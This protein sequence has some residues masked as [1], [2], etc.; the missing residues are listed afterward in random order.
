ML[1]QRARGF[2]NTCSSASLSFN[3]VSLPGTRIHSGPSR[4]PVQLHVLVPV[5]VPGSTRS[6]R[7]CSTRSGHKAAALRCS[8]H[9]ACAGFLGAP[10]NPNFSQAQI[11]DFGCSSNRREKELRIK[12]AVSRSFIQILLSRF[13]KPFIVSFMYTDVAFVFSKLIDEYSE[14]LTV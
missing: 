5:P 9:R 10:I 11:P 1:C 3:Q 12:R 6:A 8:R 13:F 4:V 14:F 2:Y 7:G